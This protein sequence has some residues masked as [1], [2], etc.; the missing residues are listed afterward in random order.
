MCI[1]SNACC[2]CIKAPLSDYYFIQSKIKN[3]QQIDDAERSA[4]KKRVE[5]DAKLE[6]II[7]AAEHTAKTTGKQAHFYFVLKPT[8]QAHFL[9]PN[10]GNC[11][12]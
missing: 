6:V 12:N 1:T 10:H 8:K 3:R 2:Y 11:S 7:S 9:N 4:K 5:E